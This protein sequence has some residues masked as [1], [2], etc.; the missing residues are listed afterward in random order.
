MGEHV[1]DIVT[2]YK[3]IATGRATYLTGC[4]RILVQSV[5]IG[6]DGKFPQSVWI[7]EHSLQSGGSG[8]LEKK[9]VEALLAGPQPQD[10]D[11][12]PPERG[13]P[14]QSRGGPPSVGRRL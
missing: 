1:R 10:E 11:D 2:G 3:G 6:E 13:Q 5:H 8:G 9:V 14:R 12:A 7:D 4:D